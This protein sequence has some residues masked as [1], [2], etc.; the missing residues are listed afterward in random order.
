MSYNPALAMKCVL[1]AALLAAVYAFLGGLAAGVLITET[2]IA[3][4]ITAWVGLEWIVGL[5]LAVVLCTSLGIVVELGDAL[6]VIRQEFEEDCL[7][8]SDEV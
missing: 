5:A 4:P 2:G 7:E 8:S 6:A 3:T 1:L